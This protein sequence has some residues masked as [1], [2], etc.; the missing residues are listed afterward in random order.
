MKTGAPAPATTSREA[1]GYGSL[2]VEWTEGAENRG[3]AAPEVFVNGSLSGP[4][5]EMLLVLAGDYRIRVQRGRSQTREYPCT[6]HT[7][8][9]LVL[10]YES[11]DSS[12]LHHSAVAAVG[13]TAWCIISMIVH[14]VAPDFEINGNF[15]IGLAVF[16]AAYAADWWLSAHIPRGTLKVAEHAQDGTASPDSLHTSQSGRVIVHWVAAPPSPKVLLDG[17]PLG[18]VADVLR[19]RPGER[20]VR[21]KGWFEHSDEIWIFVPPGALIELGIE[22]TAMGIIGIPMVAIPGLAPIFALYLWDLIDWAVPLIAGGLATSAA[23]V[24][25]ASRLGPTIKLQVT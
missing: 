1:L 16:G 25:V 12:G 24:Y 10:E 18:R 23:M 13:F 19:V 11:S 3:G 15:A 7:D 21:I 2:L 6:I 22:R 5:D 8:R 9:V 20:R 14:V 17:K 4:V